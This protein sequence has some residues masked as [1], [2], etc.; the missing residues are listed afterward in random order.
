MNEAKVGDRPKEL[1][2]GERVVITGI[3]LVSPLGSDPKTVSGALRRG[4]SGV[5]AMADWAEI[6]GL[7]ARV[8]APVAAEPDARAIPRNQ[9]RG[10]GRQALF[11]AAAARAAVTDA[12]LD[13]QLL[14]SGEVGI[15]IGSTAGSAQ[16]LH[17][18]FFGKVI[19]QRSVRAVRSTAFLRIMGHT[20][21][22]NVAMLL[23]L[24]GRV[25]APAS[26]CTSG[27]Q[28]IGAG[29]EALRA[30][31]QRAMLCGG[32]DEAH[33]TAA[34]VFDITHAASPGD[35]DHP[36][37]SPR[38]FDAERDGLV[39]GEGSGVVV[40]ERLDSARERG[41]RIYGEILGYAT[42]CDATHLSQPQPP[43]MVACMRR[44][45][46]AAGCAPDD[47]DY[48]NAHATATLLG[49]RAEAEATAE[50]FGDRVAV[51]STKGHTGH[52][53]GACGALE[54]IFCL[55]M[56]HQRFIAPTRN[57]ERVDPACSGIRHVREAQPLEIDVA[58]NNNF[59]F[60]GVNT[61]LLLRR[62]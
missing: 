40:L 56:M 5:V 18:D 35:P 33:F 11:A 20:C 62:W 42:N 36:Q 14:S 59:A 16:S 48:I 45:L 25:L 1:E 43:A 44:V 7:H 27:S 3:G 23:G 13:G 29:Y 26:A 32:A 49:D 10:M 58:L 28:A 9:R 22:A 52:T 34:A 30:G 57:L 12:D 55:M 61:S 17:D 8:A 38:P 47:V 60:G 37:R 54:T 46:A 53:L 24:K 2:P 19:S 50:L 21:A 15:A 51:S 41:A 31:E 6:D 4:E 39:V